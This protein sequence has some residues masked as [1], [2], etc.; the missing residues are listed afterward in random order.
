MKCLDPNGQEH[1]NMGK[2]RDELRVSTETGTVLP[3]LRDHIEPIVVDK[4]SEK[5]TLGLFL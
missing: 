5:D 4:V 2:Q 1:G 3:F